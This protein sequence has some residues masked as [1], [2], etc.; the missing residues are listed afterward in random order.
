MLR[1][2]IPIF[3]F[4]LITQATNP[5]TDPFAGEQSQFTLTEPL[6]CNPAQAVYQL[7]ISAGVYLEPSCVGNHKVVDLYLNNG[8]NIRSFSTEQTGQPGWG[9][10]TVESACTGRNLFTIN[11][12]YQIP[13]IGYVNPTENTA[14]GLILRGTNSS[15]LANATKNLI[16]EGACGKAIWNIDNNPAVSP[17]VMAY[18]LTLKDNSLFSCQTPSSDPST[19][20]LSQGQIAGIAVGI[21][22]AVPA[23]ITGAVFTVRWIFQK[24]PKWFKR[25]PGDYDKVADA[26]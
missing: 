9:N 24:N 4:S 15:I 6:S 11:P 20:S 1:L 14:N 5:C 26:T 21:I 25:L 3:L 12:G 17:Q 8:G 13:G 2:F 7:Q 10:L 23:A 22:L 16:S 18:L 19:K